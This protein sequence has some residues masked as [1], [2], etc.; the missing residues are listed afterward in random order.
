[1][2]VVNEVKVVKMLVGLNSNNHC[3]T[4]KRQNFTERSQLKYFKVL[5]RANKHGDLQKYYLLF[6]HFW[7]HAMY[8]MN[9]KHQSVGLHRK[10]SLR[11]KQGTIIITELLLC[12]SFTLKRDLQTYSYTNDCN[13]L[14]SVLIL[15][16]VL[17][18]SYK[19]GTCSQRGP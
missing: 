11:L 10:K 15:C 8:Q 12:F 5:K 13:A 9:S 3:I 14:L 1:M 4:I 6:K 7:M 17:L 19:E 2:I 18:D 16:S